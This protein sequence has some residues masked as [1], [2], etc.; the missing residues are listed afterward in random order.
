MTQVSQS[1]LY[2]VPATQVEGMDGMRTLCRR[3]FL[4]VATAARVDRHLFDDQ[5][6]RHNMAGFVPATHSAAEEPPQLC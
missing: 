4:H 3:M 2:A 6:V 5:T 1:A